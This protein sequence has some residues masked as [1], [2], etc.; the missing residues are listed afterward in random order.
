MNEEK[1]TESCPLCHEEHES[2]S[3]FGVK[4]IACPLMLKDTIMPRS[5]IDA[6]FQ[7]RSMMDQ[8]V[9]VITK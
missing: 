4:Y 5:T 7:G 8:P 9:I 6:F 3:L 1:K 2:M